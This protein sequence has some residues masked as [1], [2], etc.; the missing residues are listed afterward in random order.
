MV[1][2]IIQIP[3][4]NEEL[5]L[6]KTYADLPKAIEGIDCI[7]TL[8][9]DDGSTDKTIEVAQKLGITHIVKNTRNRGLAIS[10]EKGIRSCL[11][12]GADIIV[13][14]DGDNQYCGADIAKLVQPILNGSA[15]VVIGDRQIDKIKHFSG[16]K[17][18]LQKMGSGLVRRLSK[19]EVKDTVSGFRAYSRETALMMNIV[20]DFSYTIENIIQMGNRKMK[21]VSVPINTNK[22]ERESRLFKSIPHFISNQLVTIVRAYSTYRALRVFSTMGFL[23]MLPGIIGFIRFL[24][25]YFNGQGEGHVQSLIFSTSFIIIG[26]LMLVL[27]IIADLISTNRKLIEKLT[28]LYKEDK[29]KKK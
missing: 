27:G 8:I 26:F 4:Y 21:I 1:K 17:K 29:W 14:T 2:L 6:S 9:I 10:F 3:C 23:F 22:K 15:D 12:K 13:N 24:Y 19:T 16:F 7:E 28:E 20:T 11:E 25:Y 18:M 5:T